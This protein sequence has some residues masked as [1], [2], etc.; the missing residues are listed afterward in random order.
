ALPEGLRKAFGVGMVDFSRPAAYLATNFLAVTL[1][2]SLFGG[3]LGARI[4]AK[5]ETMH[6][7]EM[8]YAQPVSRVHV[9][10]GKPAAAAGYA[11]ALPRGGAIVAA[12][13]R[14]AVVPAPLEPGL[15]AALFGGAAALAV[16]FAGAGML[17][18]ALVRDARSATGGA[19]AIVLGTYFLGALS[20][21][22]APP[23]PPPLP[24]PY[25]PVQAHP[26]LPPRR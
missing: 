11:I 23:P 5:E 25:Q 9:L 14:A 4:V 17:V 24:S 22:A 2:A 6:T 10:A 15:I 18:A 20:A 26:D 3:L 13:I 16:C 12:A 21:I 19:L 1:I 8:L 7:A